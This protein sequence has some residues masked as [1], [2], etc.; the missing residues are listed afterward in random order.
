MIEMD[1]IKRKRCR[2]RNH[3]SESDEGVAST[4]GTIMALLVFLSLMSLITQQYV[5][6][7]MEDK[8]AY[9]VDNVMGQFT[10][11]KGNVDNLVIS[12]HEDYPMYSTMTLGSEGVPLFAGRSDGVIRLLPDEGNITLNFDNRDPLVGSGSLSLE[13]RN[14]YFEEQTIA[15][16]NGAILLEQEED[17]IMRA[18]PQLTIEE[19][20]DGNYS[21]DIHIIDIRGEEKRLSGSRNI[22]VIT[23][24]WD[25][26]RNSYEDPENVQI[27]IDTEYTGGWK[28]WIERETDLDPTD[29]S[30]DD[31]ILELDFEDYDGDVNRLSVTYSTIN[32]RISA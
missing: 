15:Y 13:A 10:Q 5:P 12:E 8:E 18:P 20:E 28:Q 29:V 27:A 16:Q 23:E 32:M 31:G 22:G 17:S 3:L 7:W 14:R 30:E 1:N 9:H 4:V 6:V 26:S 11:I 2:G 21:I 24:L 19:Q 25:T